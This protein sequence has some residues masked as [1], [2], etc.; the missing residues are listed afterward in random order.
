MLLS[1]VVS[2]LLNLFLSYQPV[3]LLLL[4]SVAS[5]RSS[6]NFLFDYLFIFSIDLLSDSLIDSL[7]DSS[8]DSLSDSSINALVDLLVDFLV[9]TLPITSIGFYFVFL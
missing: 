4:R 1:I 6:M 7:F 2:I 5:F 8:I 3:V 9:D